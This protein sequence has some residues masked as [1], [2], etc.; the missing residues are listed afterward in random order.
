[1]N[2][3]ET[4][5]KVAFLVESWKHLKCFV[6]QE[7]FVVL[8][9]AQSR[10]NNH[11][12]WW[13]NLAKTK[14]LAHIFLFRDEIFCVRFIPSVTSL[15]AF[16]LLP[17]K[18]QLIKVALSG[19]WQ[20]AEQEITAFLENVRNCQRIPMRTVIGRARLFNYGYC[21]VNPCSSLLKELIMS[22]IVAMGAAFHI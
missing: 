14:M 2:G 19:L 15:F 6:F 17:A 13:R 12:W 9:T 1:M 4:W 10:T 3:M 11:I 21:S 5:W 8:K 22:E 20:F 16:I 7:Q 18:L